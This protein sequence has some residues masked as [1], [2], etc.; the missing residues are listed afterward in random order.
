VP[1]GLVDHQMWA[2]P[3]ETFGRSNQRQRRPTAE[4]E[5]QRWLTSLE[6]AQQRVPETVTVVTIAD[7][8][9][10]IFDLFALP[11]REG[12]HILIR[13]THNRRVE[14]AGHLWDAIRQKPVTG[15][16][17]LELRRK[18]DVPT[19]QARMSVRYATLTIQPPKSRL[20]EPGLATAGNFG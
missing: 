3:P 11:R 8:E 13:A 19:R 18:E 14:T 1:L 15:Q 17:T 20:K 6:R 2:R 4:K 7:S 5:S 12:S 10:D 16:Y 9:A